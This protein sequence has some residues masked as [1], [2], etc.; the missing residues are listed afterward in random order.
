VRLVLSIFIV[1]MALQGAGAGM[2]GVDHAAFIDGTFRRGEDVTRYCLKCHRKE[3]EEILTT[4]HWKW[5]GPPRMI[6]GLEGSGREYGKR[7]LLNNFCISIEGGERC[8]NQEMC[9]KCHPSYGWRDN[10][11]DFNDITK[12]DCLVC[13]ARDGRYR[14]GNAGEPRF[15]VEGYDS[16]FLLKA[17]RSVG[18]PGRANCGS[19]HFYGGGGD[20]VKH[21][22][23]DSTLVNPSRE[24]DVHMG[25]KMNMACQDC[26]RTRNHRIAG[27]STFLATHDGR[28]R[29]GDCHD[30]PHAS[31]RKGS[32]I[33]RHTA[34]VACQT[35]HIPSFARE[36]ATKIYWD[37]STV[38]MDIES[39]EEYG[40][41][42]Y[43]KHKGSFRW[44]K[45]VVPAY[46]WYNG[47]IRRYLKGDRIADPR[48]VVYISRPVGSID[49]RRS[50]IYPFKV[51]RGRQPMDSE[52]RYLLVPHLYGGL[53]THYD[54]YR[55]LV[56]G[57]K[58]S[59]LRFSGRFGFVSTAYYGSINHEVPPKEYALRCTDCHYDGTRLDW[60]ALG[61]SGDPAVPR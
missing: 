41:E 39:G 31:L 16:V 60:K 17:A 8:A 20:G 44:G 46:E 25:G 4:P 42:T 43:L 52:Y 18:R 30:T 9:S 61:Y 1:I 6:E 32:E 53:W 28:V 26:H 59:G 56:E 34:R 38:G 55:A 19:C 13:H 49:D 5:M 11:F 29:C 51:F 2:A 48:K 40:R 47:K 23:L 35:C 58:G 27:A 37:W 36:M 21:G 54:W 45:N 33:E 57:A 15:M 10:T 14:R 50:K 7:N 3:A 24:H 12:I 22:D